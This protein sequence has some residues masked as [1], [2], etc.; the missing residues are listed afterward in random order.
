NSA[1]PGHHFGGGVNWAKAGEVGFSLLLSPVI[2]FAMA[3]TLLL[4]MKAVFG[5][6]GSGKLFQP[7]PKDEP[8]PLVIRALLTLTCGS[9]SFGHG[10]NDGQKGVG[11]VMLIL[12][13]LVPASY[14]LDRD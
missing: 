9:V 6:F 2:G 4:L 1:L 11:I 3:A 12:M 5:R 7:P 10:M 14:A 8:P 13:G